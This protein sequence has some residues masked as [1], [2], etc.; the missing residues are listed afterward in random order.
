MT[1]VAG[2]IV[3][4][5]FSMDV[6]QLLLLSAYLSVSYLIDYVR[7]EGIASQKDRS[8]L[9]IILHT[10]FFFFLTPGAAL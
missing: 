9:G 1:G 4:V 10:F 5:S 3:S 2:C 8:H 7:A 6:P